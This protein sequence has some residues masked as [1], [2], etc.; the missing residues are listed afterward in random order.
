MKQSYNQINKISSTIQ[1]TFSFLEVKHSSKCLAVGHCPCEARASL[2]PERGEGEP[3]LR[4]RR[5]RLLMASLASHSGANRI[6]SR[7][8]LYRVTDD[9]QRKLFSPLKRKSAKGRWNEPRKP[10]L[11]W[12]S[13]KNFHA[14]KLVKLCS[15]NDWVRCPVCRKK[16]NKRNQKRISDFMR[17]MEADLKSY[18]SLKFLT[19]TMKKDGMT[20]GEAREKILRDFKRLRRTKSWKK[21]VAYFIA[22]MEVVEGNVHLHIAL[23]G[24]FWEQ[25]EISDSWFK[26]TGNSMIVDIRKIDSIEKATQELCKYMAKD[27]EPEVVDDLAEFRDSNKNLRYMISGRRPPSLDT[28]AIS[29]QSV[30]KE[31]HHPIGIHGHFETEDEASVFL[32][33]QI[34]AREHSESTLTQ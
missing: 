7:E 8:D 13:C 4:Q 12:E 28:I 29:E 26:I 31:C 34:K 27:T 25:D 5:K 19:L 23:S 22:T 33:A 11:A 20:F 1:R 18:E 9:F 14:P 32:L 3:G 21:K 16:R 17:A 24:R 6:R 30:C 2:S 10:F 15:C